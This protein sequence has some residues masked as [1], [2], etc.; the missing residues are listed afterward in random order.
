MPDLQN[1]YRYREWVMDL[2][3]ADEQHWYGYYLRH[4]CEQGI[5]NHTNRYW[6]EDPLELSV[7]CLNCNVTMPPDVKQHMHATWNLFS[8]K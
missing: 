8:L 2:T 4:Q 5:I 3:F 7:K 6:G 1:C